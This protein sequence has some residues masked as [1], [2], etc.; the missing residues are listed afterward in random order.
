MKETHF[1]GI[2]LL[3]IALLLLISSQVG[4]RM[5]V[6]PGAIVNIFDPSLK[7]KSMINR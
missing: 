2:G 3:V 1:P 4:A 5:D 6:R 7:I